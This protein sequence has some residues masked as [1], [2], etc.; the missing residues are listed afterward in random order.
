MDAKPYMSGLFA[1]AG[2]VIGATAA[3]GTQVY[4]SRQADL[5]HVRGLAY[6]AAIEEWRI[7]LRRFG[8][9]VHMI[10]FPTL[11]T[12]FFAIWRMHH[13]FIITHLTNYQ[14]RSVMIF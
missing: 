9:W 8:P 2:A 1:L 11:K 6:E 14:S 10:R 12:Y 5:R 3:I 13:L 4:E 7:R